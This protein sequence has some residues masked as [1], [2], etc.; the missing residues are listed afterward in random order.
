MPM[1]AKAQAAVVARSRLGAET[2][3]NTE[4][5]GAESSKAAHVGGP[6]SANHRPAPPSPPLLLLPSFLLFL[7]SCLCASLKAV[8]FPFASIT[9]TGAV[10]D[11]RL[12][13]SALQPRHG[14]WLSRMNP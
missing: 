6:L 4:S 8:L 3:K 11:S 13:R 1:H 2:A 7:A 9:S 10:P 14:R 12:E 5:R